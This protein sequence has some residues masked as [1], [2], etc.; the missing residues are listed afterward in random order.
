M[1]DFHG[2]APQNNCVNKM[3]RR[4]RRVLAKRNRRRTFR[5]RD[6]QLLCGTGGGSSS[7]ASSAATEVSQMTSTTVMI[8][9]NGGGGGV[10][11]HGLYASASEYF[12]FFLSKE[13]WEEREKRFEEGKVFFLSPHVVLQRNEGKKK[14]HLY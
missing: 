1:G 3:D 7:K 9:E 8:E 6:A 5:Q 13:E 11:E 14:Y 12:K 4:A 2:A 10:M